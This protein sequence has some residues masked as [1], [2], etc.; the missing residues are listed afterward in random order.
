MQGDNCQFNSW[1]L[2]ITPSETDFVS[3]SDEGFMGPR[4]ADGSFPALDFMKL[5]EGSQMI[6]MGMDVD[7]S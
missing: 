2:G 4:R 7:L 5:R 3:I 1:D 6:Y